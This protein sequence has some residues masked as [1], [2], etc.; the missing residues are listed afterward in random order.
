MRR[1]SRGVVVVCLVLALS[2]PA[3]SAGPR[4]DGWQPKNP[5]IKL[6]KKFLLRTFGD[7]L[8]IPTP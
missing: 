6:I 2:A 5:V 8:I 4:D 7:G 1:V 3:V